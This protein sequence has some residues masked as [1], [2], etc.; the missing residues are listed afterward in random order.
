MLRAAVICVALVGCS[1]HEPRTHQVVI[2]GMQ[3]VPANLSVNVGDTIVWT[4]QDVLPH[5]AT[6]GIPSP[7]A[8]DS[9]EIASRRQWSLTVS[10]AG[11]YA[12]SCTYHPTMRGTLVA[13]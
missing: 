1:K 8:F 10:A 4:N 3:F 11:D 9:K 5:T 12:Y 2:T 13:K 6:S 7:M